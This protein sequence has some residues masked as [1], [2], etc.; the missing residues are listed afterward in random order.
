MCQYC[1]VETGRIS[2]EPGLGRITTAD[3]VNN[4]A[5]TA[6]DIPSSPGRGPSHPGTKGRTR[7]RIEL[8][9]GLP[10]CLTYETARFRSVDRINP[11]DSGTLET[12]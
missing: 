10:G 12:V 4:G 11:I 3:G 8:F 6:R 7:P 1:V 2:Y 9:M 5:K